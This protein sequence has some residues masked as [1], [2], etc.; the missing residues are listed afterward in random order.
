MLV[1]AV[2]PTTEERRSYLD[3]TL[4]CF[5]AQ[6]F[7]DSE[8]FILEEAAAPL[9]RSWPERVRYE[10]MPRAGLNAGQKRNLINSKAESQIIIHFD[11]DDWYHP[12]RIATQVKHLAE[13]GKQVVGY[14]DLLYFRATDSSF[15]QYRFTG[16]PPYAPGTSMCY[17]RAWWEFN[18]FSALTV[19]E[20]SFFSAYAARMGALASLPLSNLIVAVAHDRNTFKIPFG[21]APFLSATR[22]MFPQE[23]LTVT[24][25][26]DFSN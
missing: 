13:S 3:T 24:E 5:A 17:Y 10:W 11:S 15:W 1:S 16:R 14:H 8:L 4:Q 9:E 25:G 23:F 7:K 20:D 2:V 22:D 26:G 19:G 18:R 21:N 12:A 6:T